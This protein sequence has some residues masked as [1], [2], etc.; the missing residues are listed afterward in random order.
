MNADLIGFAGVLVGAVIT[1][2]F[3]WI[4]MWHQRQM[5]QLQQSTDL[6]MQK[7]E[8]KVEILRES[9]KELPRLFLELLHGKQEFGSVVLMVSLVSSLNDD[10]LTQLVD[11]FQDDTLAISEGKVT[12]PINE[13]K[14]F[15][16][17]FINRSVERMGEMIDE[18]LS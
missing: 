7:I 10:K 4:N 1:G 14:V 9:Q 12:E 17:A 6:K 15:S 8:K 5:Q 2:V 16:A 13:Y 11:K 3:G 18:L